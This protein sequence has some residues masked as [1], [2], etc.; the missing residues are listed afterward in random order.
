MG[1]VSGK[2]K[3]KKGYSWIYRGKRWI[4]GL[5]DGTTV[6]KPDAWAWACL[7]KT[8]FFGLVLHQDFTSS[9]LDPKAFTK[10]FLSMDCSKLLLL[11]GDM[12]GGPLT[13]Y[14]TI[15]PMPSPIYFKALPSIFNYLL[16]SSDFFGKM[17]AR[18]T[19][20]FIWKGNC[21]SINSKHFILSPKNFRAI[22]ILWIKFLDV[23]IFGKHY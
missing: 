4:L 22:S 3:A 16:F 8:A 20:F 9:Y 15:L 11:R 2:T 23:Y 18:N 12:N 10:V 6:G 13:S 7:L 14:S 17:W 1:S 19:F 5:L 21:S